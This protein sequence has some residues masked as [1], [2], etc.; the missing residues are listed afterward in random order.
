[1]VLL[2]AACSGPKLE[3]AGQLNKVASLPAAF[4]FNTK[5]LHVLTTFVNR[6]QGTMSTLYGN[7]IAF[8][9]ATMLPD[10]SYPR[11]TMLTMVTWKQQ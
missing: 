9:H 2:L 11:G 7:D 1:M 3:D 6:K 10:S 8:A 4:N 5:K